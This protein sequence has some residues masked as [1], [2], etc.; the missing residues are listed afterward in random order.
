VVAIHHLPGGLVQGTGPAVISQSAPGGQDA[1]QG[2]GGKL[3]DG[4]KAGQKS[5]VMLQNGGHPGLLQHDFRKPDMVRVG[6]AS[7]GQI[8][9]V[10]V[11]PG[12]QPAAKN[13]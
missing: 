2:G 6:G 4:G 10:G 5:P 7:P 1:V 13:C 8:A 12:Q 9:A 11:I 3:H